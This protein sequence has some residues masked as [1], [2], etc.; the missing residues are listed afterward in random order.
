LSAAVVRKVKTLKKPKF[1]ITK[2][3][4]L[5]KDTGKPVAATRKGKGKGAET[6]EAAD[7]KNLLEQ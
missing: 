2:L 4:E 5:Y 7:T 3:N 6:E 1:D